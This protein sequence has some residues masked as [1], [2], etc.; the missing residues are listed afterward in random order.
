MSLSGSV[1]LVHDYLLVM[2]GAER[3][4]AAIADCWPEAPLYTLLW[5]RRAT[6]RRLPGRTI[7]P[8]YLQR[9][10]IRQ[11]GF[12]SLLPFF[13]RAVEKLPIGHPDLVISSSSAFAHGVRPGPGATH[14]CYCHSPFRYAWHES[15]RAFDET[16]TYLRPLLRQTLRRTREWDIRSAERVTHYIANSQI[17]RERIARYYGR[18]ATVVHPPVEVDRFQTGTPEDFFLVVSEVVP[19]KRVE[20]A[21]EAARRAGVPLKIVGGGPAVRHLAQEYSTS[22]TFL[23]RL[24]DAALADLYSRARALVV[25][26]VEE[27]GIAAVEAQAA[28]RPVIGPAAGGTRETVIDGETGILVPPG[29]V[30]ALAQVM[31]DVDFD[32]FSP[33]L[34]AAR[35]QR[36]SPESFRR[37]LMSEVERLIH[38]GP[39]DV[40][41]AGP[42]SVLPSGRSPLSAPHGG[43]G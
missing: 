37:A 4:F 24:G 29:D 31:R 5:D 38:L 23:G 15:A 41:D 14:V 12:R 30:D 43:Q 8:S 25:P 21:L 26:N 35:A 28:G 11:S 40:L 33:E 20:L 3:T 10:P 16:P 34:V 13:P 36:F 2:R 27:F 1:A 19:H 39:R 32:A 42:E 17:T 9:V 22:A 18:E 7:R 6:A